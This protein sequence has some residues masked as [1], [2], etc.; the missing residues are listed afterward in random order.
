MVTNE[1]N[2]LWIL[3]SSPRMTEEKGLSLDSTVDTIRL[4]F[5]SAATSYDFTPS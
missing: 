4:E 1:V 5:I 3:G 2:G